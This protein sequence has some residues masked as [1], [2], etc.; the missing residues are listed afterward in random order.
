MILFLCIMLAAGSVPQVAGD[1]PLEAP[2]IKKK[3]VPPETPPPPPPAP[4]A[5]RHWLIGATGALM[6]APSG[7]LR[8][9]GS[10]RLSFGYV[11]PS[12]KDHLGISLEPEVAF[13]GN[14]EPNAE[15]SSA[16]FFSLP[17]LASV[18]FFAGPGLLRVFV[19]PA[20]DY[21]SFHHTGAAR[22]FTDTGTSLGLG[23][24]AA[25]LF[26]LPIG[27]LGVDARFHY[28][29]DTLLGVSGNAYIITVGASYVILL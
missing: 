19:G 22:K 12:E 8:L 15:K 27:A 5:L 18:N 21:Y 7:P 13:A 23:A 26:T 9:G 20:I 10:A 29:P 14:G 17:L 3:T 25:Y 1:V 2:V 16:F 4:P 11:R 6:F 24:G 28:L